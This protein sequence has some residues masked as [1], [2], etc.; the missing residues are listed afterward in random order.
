MQLFFLCFS[1]GLG[2][3]SLRTCLFV[4][5]AWLERK[6]SAALLQATSTQRSIQIAPEDTLGQ[7]TSSVSVIVPAR[8]EE[9][10][11]ASAVRSLMA[12]EYAADKLEIVVVNDRSTDR[13]SNILSDLQQEFSSHRHPTLRVHNTIEDNANNNLRGKTRALHQGIERSTGEIIMMTDADCTVKPQW[14]REIVTVFA[15]PTVGLA[16]SFTVIDTSDSVIHQ[17]PWLKLWNRYFQRVQAL[18]WITNH[19]MASAGVAFGQ[20]LGCFGNNLSI[21]RSVYNELGGYPAIP[22]SLTEDLALLQAVSR[23]S[24]KVRYVCSFHTQV[25][26][27]ACSTMGEFIKQHRRWVLGGKALGWRGVLFVFS[28]ALLW[29]ALLACAAAG[30]WE[31]AGMLIGAR[32]LLDGVV[33][34]PSLHILRQMRLLLWLPAATPFFLLLELAVP[35]FLLKSSVEW[36]GQMMRGA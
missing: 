8:N 26:T 16:P 27:H 13:T 33:A 2:A 25:R 17:R 18:E 22:F 6:K 23:T 34:A 14:I 9:L 12:S 1:I 7:Q 10:T 24:W 32:V 21:R 5:G 29:L 28:S 15:D 11:I 3:Y 19:T 30:R 4:I 36:K 35:F 31:L 20:P